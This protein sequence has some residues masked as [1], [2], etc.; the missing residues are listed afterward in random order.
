MTPLR[1]AFLF[2]FYTRHVSDTSRLAQLVTTPVDYLSFI[3]LFIL[4]SKAVLFSL[5]PSI[6]KIFFSPPLLPL[7]EDDTFFIRSR[8]TSVQR[9]RAQ[10]HLYNWSHYMSISCSFECQTP[11]HL[12]VRAHSPPS[13]SASSTGTVHLWGGSLDSLQQLLGTVV[14]DHIQAGAVASIYTQVSAAAADAIFGR[15]IPRS[16]NPLDAELMKASCGNSIIGHARQRQKQPANWES[17]TTSS[18]VRR[19]ADPKPPPRII[20]S[21]W[22]IPI[23]SL[24][25]GGTKPKWCNPF[26]VPSSYLTSERTTSYY[27]NSVNRSPDI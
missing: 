20:N 22:G 2:K 3:Y 26:F 14:D 27:I 4:S 21:Q 7:Q 24:Q 11:H 8:L 6:N 23:G 18:L 15:I 25:R 17:I 13:S 9:S 19:P 16:V 12:S 1:M 5:P 10:F